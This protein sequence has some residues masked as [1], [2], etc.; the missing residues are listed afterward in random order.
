[1][2]GN[3]KHAD[4]NVLKQVFGTGYNTQVFFVSKNA[5]LPDLTKFDLN[6]Y[7]RNCLRAND[8]KKITPARLT[9]HAP[10]NEA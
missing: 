10:Q 8:R 6:L 5:P 3:A 9:I 7:F 2:S 4:P 1:M